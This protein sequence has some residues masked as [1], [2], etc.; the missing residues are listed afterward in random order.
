MVL[1]ITSAARLAGL[2]FDSNSDSNSTNPVVCEF[3]TKYSRSSGFL[4]NAALS[5]DYS[6]CAN[7]GYKLF[8]S[9]RAINRETQDSSRAVERTLRIHTFT[10]AY[11]LSLSEGAGTEESRRKAPKRQE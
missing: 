1:L 9:L 5:V 4:E 8:G 2:L 7:S 6:G 3:Y 11:S 10:A